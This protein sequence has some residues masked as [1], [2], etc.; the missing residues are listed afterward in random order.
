M[1]EIPINYGML[2]VFIILHNYFIYF[3]VESKLELKS[4]LS[5]ILPVN[6]KFIYVQIFLFCTESQT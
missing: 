1:Q 3:N 5:E 6:C 2:I 4:N